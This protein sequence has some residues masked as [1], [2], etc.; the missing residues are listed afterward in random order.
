MEAIWILAKNRN[1]ASQ[2]LRKKLGSALEGEQLFCFRFMATAEIIKELDGEKFLVVHGWKKHPEA[3]E[4]L[5]ILKRKG[6]SF[7]PFKELL[8]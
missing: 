6:W 8:G 3:D 1:S 7:I 2:A 4:I 5:K